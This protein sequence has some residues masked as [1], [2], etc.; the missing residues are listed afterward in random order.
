MGEILAR[1][2]EAGD[3]GAV[4]EPTPAG[5]CRDNTNGEFAPKNGSRCTNFVKCMQCR[6]YVVTAE[7]LYKLFSFYWLLVNERKAIGNRRWSR[8]YA[9]I[10]RT[11]DRDVVERGVA[12]KVFTRSEAESARRRALDLPHPYWAERGSLLLGESSE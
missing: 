1:E 4:S 12:L 7:D 6:S 9:S 2:L 5:R 8:Q 11:I 10:L 3:I